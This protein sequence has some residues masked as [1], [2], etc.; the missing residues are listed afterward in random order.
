M[1][2]SPIP[3]SEVIRARR[4]ELVDEQGDIKITLDAQTTGSVIRLWGK[5]AHLKASFGLLTTDRPALL[6]LDGYLPRVDLRLEEDGQPNLGFVQDRHMDVCETFIENAKRRERQAK[7]KAKKEP[8]QS[9][10]KEG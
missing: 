6:F 9:K 1:A 7:R 4:I 8:T 2:Q 3:P 10:R 5:D